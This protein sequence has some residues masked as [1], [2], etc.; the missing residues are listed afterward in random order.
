MRT[1]GNESWRAGYAEQATVKTHLQ[2]YPK[3]YSTSAAA[4]KRSKSATI[5]ALPQKKGVRW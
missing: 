2:V 3:L 4:T 5:S 1:T